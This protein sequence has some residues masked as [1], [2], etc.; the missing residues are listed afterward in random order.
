[1][2]NVK[3]TKWLSTG[4]NTASPYFYNG[5]EFVIFYFIDNFTYCILLF[6]KV[7]A[8]NIDGA[9]PLCDAASSGYINC[10][11]LLIAK[12]AR[13]NPVLLLSSPLHEAALRGNVL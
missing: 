13:V 6:P 10:L 2:I 1:M 7:N 8:R 12:G 4:D 5:S 3:S 9:T 11:E